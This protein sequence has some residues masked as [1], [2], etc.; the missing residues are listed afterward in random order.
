MT[1]QT[2]FRERIGRRRVEL[3]RIAV[4]VTAVVALI[5]S[6]AV[7]VGASPTATGGPAAQSPG[8][9]SGTGGHDGKGGL[10]G[11]FRFPIPFAGPGGFGP[12][13]AMGGERLGGLVGFGGVTIT[14]VDGSA[15]SLKT[16]DGWM[17][18]ITV[19]A[20]TQITK[21]TEKA[22]LSDL[23]VGDQIRFSQTKQA[24]GSYSITRIAIIVPRIDGTVS[25]TSGSDSPQGAGR[26]DEVGDGLRRDEVPARRGSGSKSDVTVGSRVD[27]RA[28]RAPATRSP[29]RS[30]R[31]SRRSS[32]AR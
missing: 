3:F 7:T 15:I 1:D 32:P 10:F 2:T 24:D 18:T 6:A 23:H 26:L 20:D 22:S 29:P 9:S 14:K 4:L 8:A 11:R 25:A 27:V 19:G 16:D 12:G 13:P 31:S 17:R 30:S 5:V 28:H 21:G